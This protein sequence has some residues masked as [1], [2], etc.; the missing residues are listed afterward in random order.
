MGTN[1]P[2]FPHLMGFTVFS[3]AMGNWWE[4]PFTSHVMNNTVGWESNGKKS[5]HS[6]RKKHPYHGKSMSI[7]F[8][9]FPHTMDFVAF[10]HAVGNWW[11]NP[12]ISHIMRLVNFFM[13]YATASGLL[14]NSK[15]ETGRAQKMQK[16]EKLVFQKNKWKMHTC[17]KPYETN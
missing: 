17:M 11:E 4:N 3:N 12:C 5:T 2:S 8:P 13:C 15:Q 9:D 16:D 6:M 1:F 7:N 10:S 14:S